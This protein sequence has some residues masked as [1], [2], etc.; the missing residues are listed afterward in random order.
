MKALVSRVQ[1]GILA[2]LAAAL[3]ILNLHN[4]WQFPVT[5]GFDARAHI[6][7]L[8]YLRENWRLPAPHTG[9]ELHQPPLYYL[10][11]F[12]WPDLKLVQLAGLGY[13][14]GLGVLLWYWLQKLGF[15]RFWAGWG[16]VLAWSLPVVLY[17]NISI[18][19][20]F[21]SGL[22]I[23]AFLGFYS[24][25]IGPETPKAIP[26]KFQ[27]YLGLLLGLA[28]LSK[29]TA[30]VVVLAMILERLLASRGSLKKIWTQIGGVLLVAGLVA[31]WFYARNLW[32]YQK[33]VVSP[34]DFI[35][36][37]SFA[38]PI[39]PRDFVFLTNIK[40]FLSG[41]LL[42]AQNY[43]WLAGTY[44]SWFYDGHTIIVPVQ[45]FSKAGFLIVWWSVPVFGLALAGIW[46][47]IALLRETWQKPSKEAGNACILIVY[48]AALLGAYLHYNFQLP[49]YSTVKGAFLVSLV[50][51]WVFFVLK[52]WHFI[53]TRFHSRKQLW[54]SVA[55]AYLVVWVAFI[56][57]HFWILSWWYR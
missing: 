53:V 37:S 46:K 41:D 9:W 24:L 10:L 11:N 13:W 15:S 14:L 35:P 57:K 49:I 1:G 5:R 17:S 47:S 38:Q 16:T 30:L 33:L 39:V 44:F 6:E 4:W 36:L 54:Q 3:L 26:M 25:K 34:L 55:V 20:E 7:F 8:V 12:L 43:S 2:C 23:M 45:P 48:T 56:I 32:N 31:G 21:L 40:P 29:A 27:A 52:G 42:Y 51:P 50:L 19:N 28:L 18:S 22:T